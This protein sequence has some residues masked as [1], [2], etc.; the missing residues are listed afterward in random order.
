MPLKGLCEMMFER[1]SEWIDE[2]ISDMEE[3][4]DAESASNIAAACATP[5]QGSH[6]SPNRGKDGT[7]PN[8]P[9]AK[10]TPKSSPSR[11]SSTGGTSPRGGS[12]SSPGQGAPCLVCT[13]VQ[14]MEIN[15]RSFL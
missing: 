12:S 6:G 15:A 3:E 7:A 11:K 2:F 1:L 14:L 13:L 10:S 8:S 4:E 5:P 9:K